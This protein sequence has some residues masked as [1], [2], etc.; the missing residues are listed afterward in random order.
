MCHLLTAKSILPEAS[1]TAVRPGNLERDSGYRKPNGGWLF[2][3]S[4]LHSLLRIG[5]LK[6]C[7]SFN[8]A[9]QSATHEPTRQSLSWLACKSSWNPK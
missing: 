7:K 8:H 2:L 5:M 6:T 9:F 4:L 3:G 1:G